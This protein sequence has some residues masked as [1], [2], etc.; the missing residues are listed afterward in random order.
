MTMVNGSVSRVALQNATA[1]TQQAPV[2]SHG[3]MP[4]T[5]VLCRDGR[6]LSEYR[7]KADDRIDAAKDEA[8]KA[9][10]LVN[11]LGVS[12]GGLGVTGGLWLWG[13][14][15]AA[16]PLTAFLVGVG[17][18]GAAIALRLA[19]DAKVGSVTRRAEAQF[20]RDRQACAS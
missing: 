14:G 2:A 13:Q 20:Q 1:R 3:L 19:S 18:T 6:Y 5:D 7:K 4:A 15:L 9:R 11:V 12:G 10:R 8:S 17:L 16:V